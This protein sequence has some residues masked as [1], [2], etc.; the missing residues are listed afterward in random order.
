MFDVI[1]ALAG[2]ALSWLIIIGIPVFGH[3]MSKKLFPN[4]E[5]LQ[6]LGLSLGILFMFFVILSAPEPN[7]L[8]ANWVEKHTFY[9]NSFNGVIGAITGVYG[10]WSF[11]FNRKN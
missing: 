4:N 8:S 5:A 2:Y 1:I 10:V 6:L 3:T 11:L 7:N 9:F